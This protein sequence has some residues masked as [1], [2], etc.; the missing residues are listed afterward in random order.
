ML[1]EPVGLLFTSGRRFEK[2]LALVVG[3]WTDTD[4]SLEVLAELL[5]LERLLC[6][7][8]VRCHLTASFH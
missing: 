5:A 4:A 6:G 1:L 7:E 3:A 2:C 8:E